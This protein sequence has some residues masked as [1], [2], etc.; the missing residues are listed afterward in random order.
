[1]GEDKNWGK[2]GCKVKVQQVRMICASFTYYSYL[3]D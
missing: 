1:M 2:P 3:Q